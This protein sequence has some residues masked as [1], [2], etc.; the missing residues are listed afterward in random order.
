MLQK[1][2]LRS[3]PKQIELKIK[4]DSGSNQT[5]KEWDGYGQYR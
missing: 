2:A 3:Q 1:M 4:T 5:H